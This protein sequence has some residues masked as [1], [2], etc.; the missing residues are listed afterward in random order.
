MNSIERKPFNDFSKEIYN[1]Q[2]QI[3]SIW[4]NTPE[5][6]EFD[7]QKVNHLAIICDG[8]RRAALQKGLPEF[9][10][11]QVGIET[12]K[13]IARACRKWNI[14]TSTFWVW[15]TENWERTQAQVSF[16]M[17]LADRSF[18]DPTFLKELGENKVRFTHIGRKDRLPKKIKLAIDFLEKKTKHFNNYQLN[19]ALDYGGLDE[20]ARN[21][22]RIVKDFQLGKIDNQLIT[23]KPELILKYLDSGNQSPPD[24]VIRTGT[25][26]EETPHTSGFMPLQ[27][28]YSG[29]IFLPDL[30]P[31]LTPQTLSETIG[32]F[33]KYERRYGR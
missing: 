3:E 5:A 31:N 11:H 22:H 24:L 14:H 10:G 2:T 1:W 26:P 20:I 30:F 16:I 23:K 25:K 13:G 21:I 19:I 4:K 8:N 15:S 28:E 6:R 9:F 33:I 29:W 12:I 32:K 17:K 18:N 27:T 7:F